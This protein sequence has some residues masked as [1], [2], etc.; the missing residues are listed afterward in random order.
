MKLSALDWT[1]F[2][3]TYFE[4]QIKAGEP[5]YFSVDSVLLDELL[6]ER[7]TVPTDGKALES[8]TDACKGLLSIEERRVLVKDDLFESHSKS[9]SPAICFVALQVAAVEL[10][11]PSETYTEDA[12]FPILRNL[13]GVNRGG[14]L[15]SNPFLKDEFEKIWA[16]F[17]EEVVNYSGGSIRSIT[18]HKGKSR[19]DLHR[20][21][22]LSQALLTGY[23]LW[24]LYK[25]KKEKIKIIK[26]ENDAFSFLRRYRTTLSSRANKLVAHAINN[27]E[28]KERLAKQLLAFTKN[29]IIITERYEK[30][31]QSLSG[32]FEAFRSPANLFSNEKE[33][34]NVYFSDSDVDIDTAVRSY[35]EGGKSVFFIEKDRIFSQVISKFALNPGDTF[36]LI[37]EKKNAPMIRATIDRATGG[38]STVEEVQANLGETFITFLGNL[39]ASLQYDLKFSAGK[40]SFSNQANKD[41][42]I[43]L[44]GGILLD[45]RSRKYLAP[46]LPKQIVYNKSEL[47][48]DSVL[49]VNEVNRTY[50]E[51]KAELE[52]ISPHTDAYYKIQIGTNQVEFEIYANNSQDKF[53]ALLGFQFK[54]GILAPIIDTIDVQERALI[55]FILPRRR[56]FFAQSRR[57]QSEVKAA[58]FLLAKE[59]DERYLQK[60]NESEIDFL[61]SKLKENRIPRELQEIMSQKIYKYKSIPLISWRYIFSDYASEQPEARSLSTNA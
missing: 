40:I 30:K 15:S 23:D 57:R 39:V 37:T 17:R 34:I 27:D 44:R 43:T 3:W 26:N 11:T 47:S 10:M 16:K 18:F 25:D 60:M 32:T 5:V 56:T 14:Y 2:L 55:G 42:E 19:K 7:V 9:F 48:S 20:E 51:F 8:L 61:Y 54:G 38:N 52:N 59:W 13:L 35:C 1:K 28:R 49:V 53:N 31:G 4:P 46:F 58:L 21:L 22:P 33:K 12:Y 36:L 41:Q 29:P 50:S 45:G 6:R 24:C